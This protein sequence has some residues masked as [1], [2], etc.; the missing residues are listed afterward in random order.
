MKTRQFVG[1][2]SVLQELDGWTRRRLRRYRWKLWTLLLGPQV[3][4]R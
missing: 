4:T 2:P 1:Q 3:A